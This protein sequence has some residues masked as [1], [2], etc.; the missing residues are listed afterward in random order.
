MAQITMPTTPVRTRIAP[1]PT[2]DPHVGTA[3]IALFNKALAVKTGGQ[4]LLRIEDTDRERYVEGSEK[5]IFEALRWLSLDYD[6]GPD[7]GG[8]YAPYRQSERSGIYKKAV[9]DLLARKQAYR[10]FCTAARLEQMRKDQQARKE[11][12]GYDRACRKL[13]E[14]EVQEKLAT[15]TVSVVRLAV[16]LEGSTSFDD[17]L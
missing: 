11:Q 6:E 4:F 16:P 13:S 3:Y 14:T 17:G 12:P 2:G 8:P 1:S 15:G 5:M 9:D 7:V 10:C